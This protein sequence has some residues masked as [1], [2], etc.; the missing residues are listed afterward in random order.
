YVVGTTRE[1]FPRTKAALPFVQSDVETGADRIG[2]LYR[3][4]G[5]MDVKVDPP[6]VSFNGN[7]TRA[8][9]LIVVHEGTRYRFGNVSFTGDVVFFSSGGPPEELTKVIEPFR[10]KPYTPAQVTNMQRAVIYY[11]KTHGYFDPK[12]TV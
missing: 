2:G 7:K 5:F 9:V 3:S 1:R 12:A 4:E 10:K 6:Q 8:D 11:Y